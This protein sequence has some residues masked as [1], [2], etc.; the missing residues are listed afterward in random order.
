MTAG[1][2]AGLIAAVALVLLVGLLAYPIIKLGKVLGE[3]QSLM[4]GVAEE[5][6]PLIGELKTT[7][8]SAND[9][10]AKVD[11]ITDNASSVSSNAAALTSL[12]AATA[13]GPLVKVAAFSYGVR[14]AMSGR[15]V[16]V[17]DDKPTGRRRKS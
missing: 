5:S 11:V 15:R 17:R 10:L 9:Q 16:G 4:R 12:V 13:G 14:S 8:V 3:A 6:V 7:V 2:I 1:Q